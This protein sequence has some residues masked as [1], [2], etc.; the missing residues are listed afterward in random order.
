MATPITMERQ[1]RAMSTCEIPVCPKCGEPQAFVVEPIHAMFDGN[2]HIGDIATRECR[3]KRESRKAAEMGKTAEVRRAECFK[4]APAWARYTFASDKEYDP[5]SREKML[6]YVSRWEEVQRGNV[7]LIL[8]G[9]VGVGKT[10]YAACV[11]NAL[12]D[13]G[14]KVLMFPSTWIVR[15]E[16]NAVR[17]F[18]AEV[19]AADLVVIDDIGAERDTSFS[20]ERMFDTVDA[21]TKS[22]KPLIVTTNISVNEMERAEGIRERRIYDRILSCCAPVRINGKSVREIERQETLR[23]AKKILW[24][25]DGCDR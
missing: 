8:S 23:N 18:L 6:N 21:R 20:L 3:C 7:G 25:D 2:L 16:F 1:T 5:S 17:A 10:F 22:R 24:G 4:T 12:I 15:L 13:K 19:E 14:C 11:A 9:D